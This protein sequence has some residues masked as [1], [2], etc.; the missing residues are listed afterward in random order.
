MCGSTLGDPQTCKT[1]LSKQ[2]VMH[3]TQLGKG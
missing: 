3:L 2:L 1:S